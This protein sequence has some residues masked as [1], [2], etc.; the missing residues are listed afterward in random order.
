MATRWQ[1]TPVLL[2]GKLHGPGG[3]QSTGS[4]RVRHNWSNLIQYKKSFTNLQI[5]A[6]TQNS[7]AQNL[8]KN[9]RQREIN[10]I[11]HWTVQV[12]SNPSYLHSQNP[13]WWCHNCG[14]SLAFPHAALNLLFS[15]TSVFYFWSLLCY[16]ISFPHP[17][18]GNKINFYFMQ[19]SFIL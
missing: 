18:L 15:L 17:T 11:I 10:Y 2:L 1:P 5:K 13:F 3:L 8:L 4:Q 16:F 9:G 14:F 19:R 7:W 6:Y 12:T